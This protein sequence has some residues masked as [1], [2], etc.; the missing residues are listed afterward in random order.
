MVFVEI[1][2]NFRL[3]KL[4][5]TKI[6]FSMSEVSTQN[7][8]LSFLL[9]LQLHFVA[10]STYW[11]KMVRY[12]LIGYS[13]MSILDLYSIR[14]IS[15]II[16]LFLQ[17]IFPCK[18]SLLRNPNNSCSGQQIQNYKKKVH[19]I[20]CSINLAGHFRRHSG[21]FLSRTFSSDQFQRI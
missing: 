21:D 15:L 2:I 6:L 4:N 17:N 12:S 11:Q 8:P 19:F 16:K 7:I 3:L 1:K 18:F 13:K 10:D 9:A 20:Y 5:I 14:L